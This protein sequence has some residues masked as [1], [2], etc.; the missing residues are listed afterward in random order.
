M[1]HLGQSPPPAQR[2]R[3]TAQEKGNREVNQHRVVFPRFWN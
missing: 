2:D 1:P 3:D